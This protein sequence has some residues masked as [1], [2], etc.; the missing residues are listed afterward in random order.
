MARVTRCIERLS[1][2][3]AGRDVVAFAHGG[4]I[5]AALAYACGC[6]PESALSFAID[7]LSITRLD[8]IDPL[9]PGAAWRV[10]AVNQP[11]R[12]DRKAMGHVGGGSATA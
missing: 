9:G 1:P 5:R 6:S 12:N 2:R 7:N 10:N 3:H 8:H 11:P 4:T